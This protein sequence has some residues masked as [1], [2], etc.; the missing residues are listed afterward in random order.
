MAAFIL[1]IHIHTKTIIECNDDIF[2]SSVLHIFAV[3]S[4]N[5]NIIFILFLLGKKNI[6]I[7]SNERSLSKEN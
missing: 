2:Y 5:F 1:E 6:A 4:A 3:Y 7:T